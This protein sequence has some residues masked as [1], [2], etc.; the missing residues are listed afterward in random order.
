[1]VYIF[2]ADGFEEIEAIAPAD[3]LR[4][5][6]ADVKLVGVGSKT[7]RSGRGI[8][9][10]ADISEEEAKYDKL[11]MIILPGGVPGV[12]NLEKSPVV[13]NFIDYAVKNN[14]KISAI[15]AAPS[16]LGKLKVLSGYECICYPGYEDELLNA[17]IS[18]KFVITDRN[19]TTAKGAGV[20][21]EFG[22]E[23][24]KALYGEARS[25]KIREGIQA[26]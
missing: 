3:I 15:C 10:N 5:A 6:G 21:V 7:V 18:E 12:D 14:I 22:L 19:I 23:L 25:N 2:L 4:R 24:V 17:K 1:M 20:A 16:I 9:I 26:V 13:R 11:E 8:S